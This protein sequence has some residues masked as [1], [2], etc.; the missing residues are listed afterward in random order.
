MAATWGALSDGGDYAQPSLSVGQCEL[1]SFSQPR[2]AG[3]PRSRPTGRPTA[4]WRDRRAHCPGRH[5]SRSSSRLHRH[6]SC[7]DNRASG[8]ETS[9]TTRCAVAPRHSSRR[10]R[11]ASPASW[12]D[13]R[14]TR[15][16]DLADFQRQGRASERGLDLHASGARVSA[17]PCRRQD[18]TAGVRAEPGVS[19]YS[20]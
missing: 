19:D 5:R 12:P 13:A 17:R 3:P 16:T 10:R 2:K 15:G 18:S 6:P 9:D 1:R 20:T 7:A 4:S 14:T 11:R 8:R